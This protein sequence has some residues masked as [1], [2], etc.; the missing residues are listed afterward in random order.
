MTAKTNKLLKK[1]KGKKAR[2]NSKAAEDDKDL[3]GF[4]EKEPGG[5]DGSDGEFDPEHPEKA[6]HKHAGKE[7]G[8]EPKGDDADDD[9]QEEDEEDRNIDEDHLYQERKYNLMSE[10][11]FLVE[12]PIITKILHLVRGEKIMGNSD[13]LNAAICKYLKRVVDLLRADWIFYQIDYLTIFYEILS[14]K[15]LHV[16]PFRSL[17]LSLSPPFSLSLTHM[18]THARSAVHSKIGG[19]QGLGGLMDCALCGLVGQR[20]LLPSHV[21]F[22]VTDQSRSFGHR[23]GINFLGFFF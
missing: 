19:A 6:K 22:E 1:K 17:S 9:D 5:D 15:E 13:V 3:E 11:A 10:F 18:H 23:S 2:K 12:Y 8:A 16:K 21:S 14:V 20:G 4:I 7:E